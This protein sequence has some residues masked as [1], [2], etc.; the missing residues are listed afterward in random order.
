MSPFYSLTLLLLVTAPLCGQQ[1]PKEVRPGERTT[2]D[3]YSQ[4]RSRELFRACDADGD[5]RLD[6]FE[7][8]DTIE[9][10]GELKDAVRFRR[11]DRDRDGYITW[12]EFDE[13]YRSLLQVGK[14]LRLRPARRLPAAPSVEPGSIPAGQPRPD[15]P[16]MG[17]ADPGLPTGGTATGAQRPLQR[18]LQLFDRNQDGGLDAAEIEAWV[19]QSGLNPQ[20]ASQLRT[21]DADRSGKLEEAEL[22]MFFRSTGLESL[23][24]GA[25]AGPSTLPIG[26]PLP[27]LP[28]AGNAQKTPL[29]APWDHCD[30]D[31][32]GQLD[33]AE[34]AHWLRQIDPGLVRW[35]GT[36][37]DQLDANR[38][39]RLPAAELGIKPPAAKPAVKPKT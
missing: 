2:I 21:L 33:R 39:G 19:K 12:T 27:L 26:L 1:R 9:D 38:D 28:A 10:L 7:A 11:I 4:S 23:L 8:T 30:R 13:Y 31:Q 15:R 6:L 3:S 16:G 37:L 17:Q 24:P 22:E 34:L 36:I 20:F 14:A 25:P 5:D 32:D 18:F 29:P 35:A